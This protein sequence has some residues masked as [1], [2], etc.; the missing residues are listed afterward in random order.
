MIDRYFT[1]RSMTL[2][3]LLIALAI[4][5]MLFGVI[6]LVLV[7]SLDSFFISQEDISLQ[8]VLDDVLLEITDGKFEHYGLIDAVEFVRLSETDVSFVP[9]WVDRPQNTGNNKRFTLTKP[10]EPGKPLPFV[11]VKSPYSKS[12]KPMPVSF[13]LRGNKGYSSNK[14]VIEF[15]KVL[16]PGSKV[17]AIYLPKGSAKNVVFSLD[18]NREEGTLTRVYRNIVSAIPRYSTKEISVADIRFEY[19][20]NINAP[21]PVDLRTKNVDNKLFPF[22]TAI[23]VWV[24]V[25]SKD[26]FREGFAYVNVRNTRSSGAGI[27]IR[28]G[29]SVKIPDSL[30]IRTLSIMNL[31]EVK[32]GGTITIEAKPK[33]GRAWKLKMEL[34]NKNN[35]PM[36]RRYSIEYPPQSI[37]YTE[38]INMSTDVALNLLTLG[39]TGRYDYDADPDVEDVVL[40]EGDVELVVTRMDAAGASLYVRP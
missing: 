3:E 1:K 15:D 16:S 27:I 11:E 34:S 30:H 31:L 18:W 39:G 14:D 36:I 2:I 6:T 35:K 20:D 4:T 10:F 40:L 8:R 13:Y 19:F 25:A 24:K 26:K 37:V 28:E 9:L 29:T 23:R 33:V 38:T 22:V 21:I 12:F 17:R 7:S 32:D 5:A